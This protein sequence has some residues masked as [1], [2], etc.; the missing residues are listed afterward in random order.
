MTYYEFSII[1]IAT[2]LHKLVNEYVCMVAKRLYSCLPKES[3]LIEG[4]LKQGTHL[5]PS[6][7][8]F[9]LNNLYYL[10]DGQPWYPVMGEIHYGRVPR[11]D[12]EESILKM[13]ASGV[14][15][16]ATYVFW[17]YH[18]EKENTYIWE[19]NKDLRHFLELCHQHGMYVWLRIG[20]W[21]HGEVRYGGFPIG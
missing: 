3:P 6:G 13:K 14:T 11:A 16:I 15:V 7:H 10:K 8:S 20:P 1:P 2:A 21:C 4:Y 18:E 5:S 17:N 9:S 19:G 12:W